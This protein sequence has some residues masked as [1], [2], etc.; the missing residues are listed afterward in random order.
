MGIVKLEDSN[1]SNCSNVTFH[2]LNSPSKN[3]SIVQCGHPSSLSYLPSI[4]FKLYTTL[5]EFDFDLSLLTEKT[6]Y[7]LLVFLK[8][9]QPE[10]QKIVQNVREIRTQN[11]FDRLCIIDPISYQ[12]SSMNQYVMFSSTLI[13]HAMTALLVGYTIWK[14][15]KKFVNS[16]KT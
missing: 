5:G 16:R 3:E 1:T 7:E 4:N 11:C 12:I 8:L 2:Y 15:I 6:I 10:I 9:A 14:R 13:T